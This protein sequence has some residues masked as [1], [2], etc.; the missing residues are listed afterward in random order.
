MGRGRCTFDVLGRPS[1]WPK[2]TK[3]PMLH[4]DAGTRWD[5]DGVKQ[6]I[7]LHSWAFLPAPAR[8]SLAGD[9]RASGL[10]G[11]L[12]RLERACVRGVLC[13]QRGRAHT[14]RKEADHADPEQLRADELQL[15]ADSTE[16]AER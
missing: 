9:R 12:S 1:L 10:R 6:E 15:R 3:R 11:T 13:A 7:H 14:E 5:S 2:M 16:L 8:E 4:F